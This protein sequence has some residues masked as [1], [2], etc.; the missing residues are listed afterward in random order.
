MTE[1]QPTGTWAGHPFYDCPHE[2]CAFDTLNENDFRD[3]LRVVHH[4]VE[5]APAKTDERYDALQ[6]QYVGLATVVARTKAGRSTLVKEGYATE[7]ADGALWLAPLGPTDDLIR[8]DAPENDTEKEDL[9]N[10]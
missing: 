10:A 6:G 3:H 7:G 2:G 9:G 4:D 8:I 5:P 1:I